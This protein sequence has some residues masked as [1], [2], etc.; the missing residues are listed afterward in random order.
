MNTS[1]RLRRRRIL[2]S[3]ALLGPVDAMDTPSPA[4][5]AP[6]LEAFESEDTSIR[7]RFT[8]FM[9]GRAWLAG[10]VM[11]AQLDLIDGDYQAVYDHASEGL[12]VGLNERA[13]RG[14]P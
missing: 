11:L 7:P 10:W 3:I 6:F 2:G 9:Q 13:G 8:E 5:Q 1:I 14:E 4:E 12:T